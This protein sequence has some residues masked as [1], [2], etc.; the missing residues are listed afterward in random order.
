MA[1]KKL[2]CLRPGEGGEAKTRT[3]SVERDIFPR[4]GEQVT[5]ECSRER[6][7]DTLRF[8]RE[9][10]GGSAEVERRGQRNVSPGKKPGTTWESLSGAI[11]KE[12]V[13]ITEKGVES[14][15]SIGER[16]VRVGKRGTH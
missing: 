8:R 1:T 12:G 16:G 7:D 13:I 11:N 4:E 10:T 6:E 14:E 3:T 5:E 15:K 2:R 9:G